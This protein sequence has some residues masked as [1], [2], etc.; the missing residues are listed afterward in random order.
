MG[1]FSECCPRDF[2]TFDITQRFKIIL[3]DIRLRENFDNFKL[4]KIQSFFRGYTLRK[5]LKLIEKTEKS[6]NLYKTLIESGTQLVFENGVLKNVDTIQQQSPIKIIKN[7][8][9]FIEESELCKL[10]PLGN[11]PFCEQSIPGRLLKDN[12]VEKIRLKEKVA[13]T[14]N[15][16]GAFIIE[17]K[18]VIRYLED[19]KFKLRKYQI[20][21]PNGS[22]YIGYFNPD[23]E[24]EGYGIYILEDGSKYEGT[25][26]KNKMWGRG[27]LISIQGDYFEGEF[28]EDKASGF[29]K[30][31]N[32]EGGVYIGYWKNDKQN[33]RGEELY[34]DGSQYD[35]L[36]HDGLKQG[37]G[38]F[39]W[40]DGSVYEGSFYK[41]NIE[42]SG[43]YRWMDG[44]IYHGQ[45]KN[46]M[47]EGLGL[48]L[49]PDKKKY[50]GQYSKD[51]KSGY[52][53]FLWPDGKKF[54]GQWSEGKQNG[55]GT[56]TFNN[57]KK[58]GSWK[59]GLK[60]K[61]LDVAEY[62]NEFEVLNKEIFKISE[63]QK[64][65]DFLLFSNGSTLKSDSSVNN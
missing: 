26:Q 54:E 21:Y 2:I 33:G 40:I 5:K 45:W 6:Q 27:R 63:N 8:S 28:K 11:E 43:I 60:E 52:G 12:E 55:F 59:N 61:W 19:Y 22:V 14:E 39:T 17:E 44:R 57:K 10:T 47:M 58:F 48:F 16:L 53:I 35:G 46:N 29:G 42:G 31:V 37:L 24:R 3:D 65:K 38:K 23:W 25:F 9:N 20:L 4:L 62:V 32:K 41:N 13:D 56:L 50:I 30:Y 1:N 15:L 51:K 49:W 18:E 36:Y 7:D 34:V 64:V